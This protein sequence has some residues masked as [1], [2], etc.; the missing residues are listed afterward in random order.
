MRTKERNC[1]DGDTERKAER[2]QQPDRKRQGIGALP[3][4]VLWWYIEMEEQK[5]TDSS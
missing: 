5:G 3:L 2:A 1:K 4:S